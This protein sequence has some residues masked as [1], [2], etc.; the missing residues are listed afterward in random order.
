MNRGLGFALVALVLKY[1]TS[2]TG[3]WL[4]RDSALFRLGS[5]RGRRRHLW[6][7]RL[8][9]LLESQAELVGDRRHQLHV[10]T[11]LLTQLVGYVER[12]V[13]LADGHIDGTS[14]CLYFNLK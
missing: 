10:K 6:Q 3:G 9:H 1:M 7:Y 2:G 12:L 4:L 8:A 14:L 5:W 13:E 11:I